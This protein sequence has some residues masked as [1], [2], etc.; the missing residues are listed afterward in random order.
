MNLETLLD[1]TRKES[2]ARKTKDSFKS[3]KAALRNQEPTRGFAKRLS[4][5]GFSLIAEV[6]IKSPTMGNMTGL[7]G[8]KIGEVHKLYERHAAVSAISVLTQETHFGGNPAILRKI[9][10]ETRKPILRKDFILDDYEVYYS[11]MIGADAILLMGN[12]I[13]DKNKFRDLHDLAVSLGMDVLCEVHFEH[14]LELLPTTV[15][16]VGINSRNFTS[17]KLGFSKYVKLAGKDITTDLAAFE[18]FDRLP[19]NCLKV[20]ES[21]LNAKNLGDILT[22]Y[23]F[24]AGL[25]G[26]SLLKDGARF[27]EEELNRFQEAIQQA[28]TVTKAAVA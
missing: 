15:K 22:H 27:A 12:V 18:L 26:T 21:G 14:E 3:V 10:R 20:A 4:K 19:S 16:L 23:A 24:N 17:A 9:R 28:S 1:A 25:V 6:K 13:T 5:S 2:E 11:R 8:S 7:A